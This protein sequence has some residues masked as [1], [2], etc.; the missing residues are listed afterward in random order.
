MSKTS[1]IYRSTTACAGMQFA[2]KNPLE[3][4]AFQEDSAPRLLKEEPQDQLPQDVRQMQENAKQVAR[5]QQNDIL[6][7]DKDVPLPDFFK[8]QYGAAQGQLPDRLAVKKAL[9]QAMTLQYPN[10]DFVMR[11]ALVEHYLNKPDDTP[12]D[13]VARAPRNY[14]DEKN[15][16]VHPPQGG[17]IS[18]EQENEEEE[19]EEETEEE[20]EEE[21]QEEEET[22]EEEEEDKEEEEEEDKEDTE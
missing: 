6:A 5:N 12:E 18:E 17:C 10:L 7:R 9:M 13:L 16:K 3:D 15:V 22:E 19:D 14:F 2:E 21:A 4:M 1:D 20:E 8:G 11:L